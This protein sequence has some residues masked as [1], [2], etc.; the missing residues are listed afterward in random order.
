MPYRYQ[1]NTTEVAKMVSK[2]WKTLPDEERETWEEIARKDKARYEYEKSIYNGPW[3]V[4]IRKKEKKRRSNKKNGGNVQHCNNETTPP[5][6][7]EEEPP[8][9]PS[10]EKPLSAFLAFANTKRRELR[11]RHQDGGRHAMGD[12]GKDNADTDELSSTRL[13]ELWKECDPIEKNRYIAQ[14]LV[15]KQQYAT[16]RLEWQRETKHRME[17]AA[18]VAVAN[19]YQTKMAKDIF[20]DHVQAQ[21]PHASWCPPASAAAR[22]NLPAPGLPEEYYT[23]TSAMVPAPYYTEEASMYPPAA[24]TGAAL[25]VPSSSMAFFLPP[26]QHGS[27]PPT[28]EYHY[29]SPPSTTITT[30]TYGYH[31]RS[32]SYRPTTYSVPDTSTANSRRGP[33]SGRDGAG[34]TTVSTEQQQQQQHPQ[35]P[36]YPYPQQYQYYQYP[37]RYGY[38][39]ERTPVPPMSSS[40][41]SVPVQPP[42]P[43]SSPYQFHN[44]PDPTGVGTFLKIES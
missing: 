34:E 33:R 16:S 27:R 35:Y 42:P 7:E 1:I 32:S 22:A 36:Q 12:V 17:A 8:R 6:G 26:S 28:D 43:A 44:S 20:E 13:A 39:Y 24:R 29:P 14:A 9:S 15:A 40:S 41:S 38:G 4:P 30:P 2:A 25:P 5:V 23:S 3:K 10:P 21:P 31:D 19:R 37:Y 11:Q 18:V